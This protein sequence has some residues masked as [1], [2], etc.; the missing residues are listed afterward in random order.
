MTEFNNEA[1]DTDKEYYVDDGLVRNNNTID[2][3]I[4]DHDDNY[5]KILSNIKFCPY[6][7]KK[8]G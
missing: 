6:C 4:P 3:V 8:L 5:T 7:G 1:L 2:L